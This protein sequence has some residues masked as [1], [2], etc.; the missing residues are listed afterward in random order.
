MAHAGWPRALQMMPG[1]SP[2]RCAAPHPRG[3]K[4]PVVSGVVLLV[5]VV[6]LGSAAGRCGGVVAAAL[7]M[8]AVDGALRLAH[9]HQRYK[10]RDSLGISGG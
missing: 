5:V 8:F 10:A 3:V 1:E 6:V 4:P 7:G 2:G 9:P